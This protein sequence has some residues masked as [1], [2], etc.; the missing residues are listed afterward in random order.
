MGK[1]LQA[2]QSGDKR[3]MLAELRDEI[4]QTI[5]GCESGRDMA[6]LSKRLM[7]VVEEIE[8]ID[9][10]KAATKNPLQVARERAQAK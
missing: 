10:R 1:L 5:E 8:E 4:A 7:E 3:K 2:V 9:H 6:A